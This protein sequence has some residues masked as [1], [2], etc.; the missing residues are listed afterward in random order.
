MF[1]KKANLSNSIYQRNGSAPGLTVKDG[2]LI[3]NRPDSVS[4]IAQACEMKKVMNRAEKVSIYSEATAFG[5]M[6]SR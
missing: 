4:G 6:M 5:N 2:M 1:S 3:N